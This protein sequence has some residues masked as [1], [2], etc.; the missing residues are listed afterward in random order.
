MRPMPR[1]QRP[2]RW[3]GLVVSLLL[4]VFL[5]VAVGTLVFRIAPYQ[6]D[7]RPYRQLSPIYHHGLKPDTAAWASWGRYRYRVYTNSLGFRDTAVRDVPPASR[8]WRVLL[9]GDSFTE[10]LGYAYEDTFAGILHAR[11]AP[12]GIE[13]LNAAVTSYSPTIYYR[14]LK[15]LIEEVKLH[16]D[17][18]I[19][20]L[21]ISDIQDEAQLYALSDDG[22]VVDQPPRPGKPATASE[23]FLPPLTG[24]DQ[25]KRW[26]R[27]HSLSVAV[28]ERLADR[29]RGGG[30]KPPVGNPGDPLGPWRA[31]LANDRGNWTFDPKVYAAYGEKGMERATRSMDLLSGL[32]RRHGLR[33]TVVVYPWPNQIAARDRDSSQVRF[34]R[35]W[36]AAHE[37]GFVD[38]FGEFIDGRDPAVVIRTYYIEGDC[39][40]NAAGH[41]L[42]AAT[43]L[44]RHPWTPGP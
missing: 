44:R 19:V 29:F 18:V 40:L 23:L 35:A 1:E 26:L 20:F 6:V 4:F 28:A 39:H 36:A 14:K 12:R 5:D 9:L 10:G 34:W 32:A 7:N 13:V 8:A 33:L 15:Y 27:E 25:L 21:D 11:L 30:A 17:E 2:R 31:V 38:L 16:L 22:R 41:R 24:T 43:M 37:S 3:A 42:V